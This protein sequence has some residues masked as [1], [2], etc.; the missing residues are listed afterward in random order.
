MVPVAPIA[1]LAP[2]EVAPLLDDHHLVIVDGDAVERASFV[3]ALRRQLEMVPR[4]QVATIEP[5]GGDLL[6]AFCRSLAAALGRPVEVA[7][8]AAWLA[9]RELG[10]AHREVFLIW[11]R[12]DEALEADV[13]LFSKLVNL[14]HGVAADREYLSSD[15]LMI[16]RAVYA[17]GD[18]L[19]A[20]AEES[21]G[22]FRA[23]S[24]DPGA[25]PEAIVR[26]T[27]DAPPALVLRLEG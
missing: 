2:A 18:K 25:P 21:A 26:E 24:A 17:G 10:A 1:A 8:D 13:R 19:G 3:A 6:A 23:W 20:Y 5:G 14:I 7:T 4:A 12:A 22:Q 16:L 27:I 15:R 9:L 11:D